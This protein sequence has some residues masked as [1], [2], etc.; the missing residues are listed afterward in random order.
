MSTQINNDC[1]TNDSK[2]DEAI[3]VANDEIESLAK[4]QK[5]LEK[6]IKIFRINKRDGVPW[7]EKVVETLSATT[8]GSTVENSQ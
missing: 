2:L 8:K 5:Q 6:S 4:K 3:K 7:P 1:Q